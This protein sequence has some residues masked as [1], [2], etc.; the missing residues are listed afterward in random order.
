M[1]SVNLVK[2]LQAI[3]RQL[4]ERVTVTYYQRSTGIANA[5][6]FD[7]GVE[8]DAMHG[9]ITSTDANGK[10]RRFTTW[11]LYTTD[12]Q[13]V[14]PARLGKVVDNDGIT[15]HVMSSNSMYGELKHDLDCIEVVD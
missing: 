3:V 1:P 2:A 5:D 6:N 14:K 13:T 9:V 12:G 7:A 10:D 11:H 8:F 15:W 4:P